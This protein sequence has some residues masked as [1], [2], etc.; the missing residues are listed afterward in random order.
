MWTHKTFWQRKQSAQSKMDGKLAL[1]STEATEIWTHFQIALH[2]NKTREN[3]ISGIIGSIC[4]LFVHTFMVALWTY[5]KLMH[6]R[7]KKKYIYDSPLCMSV[8]DSSKRNIHYFGRD[9]AGFLKPLLKYPL[10]PFPSNIS[11][12][13]PAE[14]IKSLRFILAF[15]DIFQW[16]K[17][18]VDD[19]G[20]MGWFLLVNWNGKIP[21]SWLISLQPCVN[22]ETDTRSWFRWVRTNKPPI[23]LKCARRPRFH[24]M[25]CLLQQFN[26][27]E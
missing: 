19:G 13:Y 14:W 21:F 10:L 4:C 11:T 15:L 27:R 1:A 2:D 17:P 26:S 23:N 7:K 6:N 18:S 5:T 8:S 3:I 16:E 24:A 20:Q 25:S 12:W 22:Q 9:G